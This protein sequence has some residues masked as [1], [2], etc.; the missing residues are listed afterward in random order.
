[1]WA[2]NLLQLFH[3]MEIYPHA[4]W[5]RSWIFL[6]NLRGDKDTILN[7]KLLFVPLRRKLK[8]LPCSLSAFFRLSVQPAFSLDFSFFL[9]IS[10]SLS[11]LKKFLAY[12][13]LSGRLYMFLWRHH[14]ARVSVPSNL[15]EHLLSEIFVFRLCRG[16]KW[17]LNADSLHIC[18]KIQSNP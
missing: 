1:M 11:F 3:R 17:Q 13:K 15:V 9:S 4:L 12:Y 7:L 16:E 18:H 2:W 14:P 8:Y 5:K 6:S 10:L